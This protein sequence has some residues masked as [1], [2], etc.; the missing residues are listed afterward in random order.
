MLSRQRTTDIRT[1]SWTKFLSVS[2]LVAGVL[3]ALIYCS[4]VYLEWNH[5][6]VEWSQHVVSGNAARCEQIKVVCQEEAAARRTSDPKPDASP[7]G[8]IVRLLY[9]AESCRHRLERQAHLRLEQWGR[10]IAACVKAEPRHFIEALSDS[11]SYA[12]TNEVPPAGVA[13]TF[14]LVLL[15]A[16][17]LVRLFLAEPHLGWRRL[18]LLA[19]V[20]GTAA[21]AVYAIEERMRDAEV[22]VTVATATTVAFAAVL[23]GRRVCLWVLNGFNASVPATPYNSSGAADSASTVS[24]A[25][26][27]IK[28]IMGGIAIA[29]FLVV[30]FVINPDAAIQTYIATLVQAIVIVLV[31]YVGKAVLVALRNRRG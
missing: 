8:E 30:A 2:T 10:E 4:L 29:V 17:I 13:L 14:W 25:S 19:G 9:D 20:I 31:W 16:I 3:A 28:K 22:I 23:L 15:S 12:R 26:L 11:W 18:A 5:S 7:Y 21:G 24:G 27:S 6:R 1:T